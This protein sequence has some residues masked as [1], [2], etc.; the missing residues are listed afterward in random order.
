MEAPEK[1]IAAGQLCRLLRTKTMFYRWDQLNSLP[2]E[3]HGPFWCARTQR[4]Y[5][6]DGGLVEPEHCRPGRACC[7]CG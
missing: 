7:E 4:P 1:L 2:G 3:L 6:P 5:G